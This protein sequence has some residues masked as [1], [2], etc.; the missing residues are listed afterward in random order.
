[1]LLCV[2][3]VSALINWLPASQAMPQ[4]KSPPELKAN[5]GD[6][7]RTGWQKPVQSPVLT[8]IPF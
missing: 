2:D 8:L 4:T 3:G 7:E 1:M 6:I 5:N